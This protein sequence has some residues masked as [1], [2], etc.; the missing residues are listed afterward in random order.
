[1]VAAR[2]ADHGVDPQAIGGELWTR[3]SPE[4]SLCCCRR[5]PDPAAWV[6]GDLAAFADKAMSTARRCSSLVG[7]AELVLPMWER[8][9]PAWGRPATSAT[10]SR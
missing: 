4:E 2:V 5:E 7:R 9:E 1:M 8:L 6:L 10:S 3:R